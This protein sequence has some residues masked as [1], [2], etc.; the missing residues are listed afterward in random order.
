M[1]QFL[2][3]VFGF[4]IMATIGYIS[5]MILWSLFAPYAALKKNAP[6]P[7][8]SY[9]GRRIMELDTISNVDILFL[10]SSHAFRSF[11]TRVYSELGL[12]SFNFGSASQTPLQTRWLMREYLKKLNPR[13]IIYDVYP[14]TFENEGVEASVDLIA[15]T[16]TNY[17]T[18]EMALEINHLKTYNTIIYDQF[19]EMVGL[20]KDIEIPRVQGTDTYIDGGYVESSVLSNQSPITETI[21]RSY[22]GATWHIQDSNWQAFED[23][24]DMIKGEEIPLIL[25][26]TPVTSAAYDLRLD[27]DRVDSLF[28]AKAPFYNLN[29][30]LHMDDASDFIDYDHLSQ[31]GAEK[32][33]EEIIRLLRKVQPQ[34]F[35]Q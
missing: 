28:S 31:A 35:S 4:S 27:N 11:D 13:F 26:R 30:L 29:K 23:V 9:L 6:Y 16:S 12:K 10:G 8:G 24:L 25:L 17:G 20:N 7:R 33:N 14:A 1:Q 21:K 22:A 15:N 32:V 2:R 34:L 19:R 3:K 18:F 5:L